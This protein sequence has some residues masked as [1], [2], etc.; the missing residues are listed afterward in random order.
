MTALQLTA[1]DHTARRINGVDLKHRFG[2]IETDCSYRLHVS[3]PPKLRPPQRRSL[4]GTYV[5]V[6]EPS[7]AS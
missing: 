2:D 5:P 7:A 4:I 3:L 6:G 1:N